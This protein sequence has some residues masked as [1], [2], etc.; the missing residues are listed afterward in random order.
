MKTLLAAATMMVLAG[1]PAFATA[2][3]CAIVSSTDG[4]LAVR[5]GPG[6]TNP[7]IFQLRTGQTIAIDSKPD[8]A[9]NKWWH[10]NGVVTDGKGS[11][12][13][14]EGWAYGQ[15][16]RPTECPGDGC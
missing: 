10:V 16:L 14:V 5:T 2:D 4:L 12:V 8:G 15:Y 13:E 1:S 3:G 7:A 9:G 11:T 6:T